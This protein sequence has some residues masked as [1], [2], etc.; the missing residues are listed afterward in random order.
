MY[1]IEFPEA[2]T[3]FAKDQPEYLPLPAFISEDGQVVTC[4]RF[5]LWERLLVLITG[6]MWIRQLTFNQPL[7]PICPQVKTPLRQVPE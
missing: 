7:Q 2:H 5:S 6:K 3:T 4:W 1:P